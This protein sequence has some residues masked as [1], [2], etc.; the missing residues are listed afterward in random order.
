ML[1][2]NVQI[3]DPLL[4]QIRDEKQVSL[5]NLVISRVYNSSECVQNAILYLLFDLCP[6]A[7]PSAMAQK[8]DNRFFM[9]N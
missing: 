2:V 8:T 9:L 4:S 6:L 7:T 5:A 1:I 3:Y